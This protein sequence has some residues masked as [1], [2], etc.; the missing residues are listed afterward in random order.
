MFS[1]YENKINS[2]LLSID[3]VNDSKLNTFYMALFMLGLF[4]GWIGSED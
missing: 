1:G 3:Y 4:P 2:S